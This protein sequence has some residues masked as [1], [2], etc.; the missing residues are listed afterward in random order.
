MRKTNFINICSLLFALITAVA[1]GYGLYHPDVY[2]IK[3]PGYLRLVGNQDFA[4]LAIF[5]PLLLTST[6]LAAQ[7]HFRGTLIWLGAVGY[8]GYVFSSYSFSGVSPKLF[9]LHI[10]ITAF[11]FFLLFSKLATIN[12]EEIRLRFTPV[13]P[14]R[15]TAFY[16]I[17][18]A[19][20]IGTLWLPEI[21][22]L[23]PRWF[24]KVP[25][26][27]FQ[28]GL[29]VQVLDLTFLGPLCLLAG[30]WLYFRK[31]VGYVLTAGL[32]VIIPAKFGTMILGF[33][34]ILKD[35]TNIVVSLL[36]F[37]ALAVLI[38][39][40]KKLKEEKLTSYHDRLSNSF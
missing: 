29:A 7:G 30:F 37:V 19:F 8:L 38:C 17:V 10:A 39:F 33:D 15:F 28:N 4:I 2:I 6:W 27:N 32:L 40:L 1:A 3:E 23:F 20:L 9:L 11:S 31:A 12:S 35:Q 18:N 13:T 24:L 25:L 16:M 22:P 14:F 34:L 21:L 36:T 26:V 5:V